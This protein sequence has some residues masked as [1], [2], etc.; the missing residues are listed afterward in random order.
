MFKLD[1]KSLKWSLEH[2]KSF[3]D[4]DFFPRLFEF[5]VIAHH[6]NNI[7]NHVSSIN[8]ENYTPNS[9]RIY[10]ALKT[11]DKYRVVH[12]LEPIDSIIYTSLVYEIAKKVEEYRIPASEEINFS[13]RIDP[14]RKGSFF[15]NNN[16]WKKFKEKTEE[17][18]KEYEDGYVIKADITDFYNQIYLHR[19]NNL[20]CEA[21]EGELD[22]HG[23]IIENFLMD[24]NR[25]TSRGIPVGPAPSIVLSELIMSDIDKKILNYTR[26]F[27]RYVDDI[28]IFCNTKKE[29]I[30]LLH[31][32][33]KYIYSSHRLVFSSSKTKILPVTDFLENYYLNEEKKESNIKKS[34]ATKKAEEELDQMLEE[35][36]SDSP[37]DFFSPITIPNREEI[38]NDIKEN[39]K[40]VVIKETYREIL[41][42]LLNEKDKNYSFIRH[43]IRRAKKYRVRNIIDLI[44]DNFSILIP[45]IRECI[46]YL[47][48]VINENVV[49]RK[50]EK[51]LNLWNTEYIDIPFVNH[52]LSFL[53]QSEEFNE[54]VKEDITYDMILE[55]RDKAMHAIQKK[56]TR[57]VRDHR[58]NVD[59]LGTWE[60]RGVL[61]SS[62]ILPY[63]E[64]KHWVNSV[65]SAGDIVD[66]AISAYLYNECKP[67]K[68]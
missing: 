36:R 8:L 49:K 22:K 24:L 40:F 68:S 11:T 9:P 15:T 6:W 14:S 62:S 5:E 29:A 54:I 51:F 3:Y 63:D 4:S 59:L 31:E 61:Y 66:K 57:W 1:E 19:I 28:R 27:T 30:E 44:L 52:W 16:G 65:A 23:K 7:K 34:I 67:G 55:K 60:K 58:D 13:Y 47:K 2:L 50:K 32:L 18:A 20:I 12:Q 64:M 38:L 46:I 39:Q 33:T 53:F 21:G 42:S 45:I 37:Y 48:A 26:A 17:T 10:L 43:I 25:K 35:I 41:E 56:D